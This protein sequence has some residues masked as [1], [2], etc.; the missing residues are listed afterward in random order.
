M[1]ERYFHITEGYIQSFNGIFNG[2]LT[3]RSDSLIKHGKYSDD[4]YQK[5][6]SYPRF[7]DEDWDR[8][9]DLA[10][11]KPRYELCNT[12]PISAKDERPL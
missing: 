9:K 1:L 8:Y 5:K 3:Y 7:N 12:M 11:S 10:L 2:T 6:V 4:C